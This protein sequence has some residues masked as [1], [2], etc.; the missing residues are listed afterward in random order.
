[1]LPRPTALGFAARLHERTA[2]VPFIVEEVLRDA[3]AD[4]LAV[5]RA[6][7]HATFHCWLVAPV[8]VHCRTS[9]PGAVPKP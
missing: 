4:R 9:A 6:V 5:L 8:Q 1:M 3:M 7:V 2:G